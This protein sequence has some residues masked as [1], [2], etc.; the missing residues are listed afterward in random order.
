M[1][2]LSSLGSLELGI[3]GPSPPPGS[4]HTTAESQL[5]QTA[6]QLVYQSSSTAIYR[7][8]DIGYKVI[9]AP[10]PSEE[11]VLKL[12]HER[13]ISQFLP[14]SCRKRQVNDVTSFNKRPAL[15]FKWASGITLKEW[16]QKVQSGPQLDWNIQ[17]SAAMAIARTLSDFHEGGVVYSSLTPENVVL[18][19]FE[20]TYVATFIDLSNALIYRNGNS[21]DV[22][23]SFEKKMREMD[24]KSL[25]IVLHQIFQG[26]ESADGDGVGQGP[27]STGNFSEHSRQKR[28]KQ[29]A[30]GE[31]L[32]LYLGSLTSALIDPSP[33]H[34][35][36]S[37][38]DVFLDLKFLAESTDGSLLKSKVDEST[39][40][41]QLCLPDDIFYG[42]QV[43]MSML[44]HLFQSSVKLGSHPLMATI[45][46]YPGTG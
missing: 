14:W 25:G 39:L 34:C 20:G 23:T 6:P 33:D 38:K 4:S 27:E 3:G 19:P 32:P 35:Y 8:H 15:R 18:S 26:E 13:D 46:G 10:N 31:G 5:P 22:D 12:L 37:V 16:L 29:H 2:K 36:E 45:S 41:N 43:Q 9:L 21:A 7:L 40:K 30:L 1:D 17:L 28:G 24:L 11:H 42:R 44:L